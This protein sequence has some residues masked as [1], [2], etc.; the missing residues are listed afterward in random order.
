MRLA[1]EVFRPYSGYLCLRLGFKARVMVKST[2]APTVGSIPAPW[3]WLVQ[4]ECSKRRAVFHLLTCLELYEGRHLSSSL[5][6]L[7]PDAWGSAI[8]SYLAA[9]EVRLARQR[10]VFSGA[11]AKGVCVPHAVPKGS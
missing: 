1:L 8:D 4:G 7:H 11:W 3:E 10:A 6:S 9:L 5:S 2:Q